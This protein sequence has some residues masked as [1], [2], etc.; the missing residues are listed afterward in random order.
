M[1]KMLN[2]VPALV[3]SQDYLQVF[4]HI[5]HTKKATDVAAEHLTDAEGANLNFK[6][7]IDALVKIA[8]LGKYKLG[9]LESLEEDHILN[10]SPV[11]GGKTIKEQQAMMEIQFDVSEMTH[12]T[13]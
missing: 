10:D 11:R 4:K 7:F 13:I 6:D 2:L 3:S 5:M 1:G 9:G 8:C 12:I